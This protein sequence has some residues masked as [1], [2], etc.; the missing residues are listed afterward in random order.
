MY[1]QEITVTAFVPDQSASSFYRIQLPFSHLISQGRPVGWVPLRDAHL[2][3]SQGVPLHRSDVL[4]FS[5]MCPKDSAWVQMLRRATTGA[6]VLDVDDDLTNEH[7]YVTDGSVGLFAMHA[8]L[9][10]TSTPYL[11]QVM[12]AFNPHVVTVPNAVDT[13][14]MEQFAV[15][16]GP[17][18]DPIVLLTGSSSHERDWW[19]YQK[20]LQDLA[21]RQVLVVSGYKPD[22]LDAP[23]VPWQPVHEYYQLLASADI[24]LCLI[25]RE[26]RF[27]WSKSDLKAIEAMASVKRIGDR[28]VGAVPVAT[29]CTVYRRAINAQNG[30]LIQEPKELYHKVMELLENRQEL[31]RIGANALRWVRK[32]R[33]ISKTLPMWWSAFRKAFKLHQQGREAT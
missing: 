4:L 24:V 13:Q 12:R 28:L 19:I 6:I 2:Y 18:E 16:K 7:R 17:S 26:D 21:K 30:V 25:D 22:W 14:S 1:R 8:D 23:F 32:H 31:H 29:D 5:R 20:P 33:D 27:N 9:V 11:A 3:I 15:A 10:I